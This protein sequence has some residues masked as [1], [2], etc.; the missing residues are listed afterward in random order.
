M[1]WSDG[2]S[3]KELGGRPTEDC[4]QK[5]YLL[6]KEGKL[7]EAIGLSTR[8]I[9]QGA[10]ESILYYNRG[11]AYRK[12]GFFEEAI[13]DLKKAIDLKPDMIEAYRNIDWILTQKRNGKALPLTGVDTFR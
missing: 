10:Q 8:C 9:E 12:K 4:R 2:Y 5:A 1:E 11:V 13:S 3:L 7:E 6:L